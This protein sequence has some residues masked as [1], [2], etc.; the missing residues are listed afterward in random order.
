[1]NGSVYKHKKYQYIFF[2]INIFIYIYFLNI[3]FCIYFL[4]IFFVINVHCNNPSM[5]SKNVFSLQSNRS[6]SRFFYMK[7]HFQSH[8]FVRML[9]VQTCCCG[10]DFVVYVCLFHTCPV[11]CSQAATHCSHTDTPILR[12]SLTETNGT[13]KILRPL[14]FLC[15]NLPRAPPGKQTNKQ[16][17][18]K[19]MFP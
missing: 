18:K 12:F 9:V 1:L 7:R 8:F 14:S 6:S 15:T 19:T 13:S 17:Q 3:Y 11:R 10:S 5:Y 16:T 4:Y 2:D